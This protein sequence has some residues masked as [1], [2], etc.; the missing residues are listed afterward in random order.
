MEEIL[1][2][3]SRRTWV[4]RYVAC[5]REIIMYSLDVGSWSP[6]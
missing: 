1:L 5:Y 4:C 2:E 6:Y 3:Y